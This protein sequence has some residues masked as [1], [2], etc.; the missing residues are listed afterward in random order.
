M[1]NSNKFPFRRVTYDA[2]TSNDNIAFYSGVRM[3]YAISPYF[4]IIFDHSVLFDYCS[5]SDLNVFS[6]L[7]AFIYVTF[8]SFNDY[9]SNLLGGFYG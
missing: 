1:V 3:N 6:N 7:C 4:Y 5:V 8:D 2:M 9:P